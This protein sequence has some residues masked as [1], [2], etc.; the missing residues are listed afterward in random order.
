MG[1]HRLPIPAECLFRD[2]TTGIAKTVYKAL[3]KLLRLV[4]S[5]KISAR[6]FTKSAN[7]K[8]N[9]RPTEQ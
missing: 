4:G 2:V 9:K 1:A 6:G 7:D 5:M 3:Q 8:G